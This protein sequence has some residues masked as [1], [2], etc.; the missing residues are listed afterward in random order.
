MVKSVVMEAGVIS[1]ACTA[2][3]E[4]VETNIQSQLVILARRLGMQMKSREE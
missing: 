1:I 3:V 2:T 4:T